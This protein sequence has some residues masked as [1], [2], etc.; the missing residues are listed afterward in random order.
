MSK[1]IWRECDLTQ[2]PGLV[3]ERNALARENQ[4]LRKAAQALHSTVY[5]F[6]Q[7]NGD[8]P[9]ILRAQSRL[10][11]GLMRKPLSP[12]RTLERMDTL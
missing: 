9:A 3:R 7:G 12:S 4:A 2:I 6:L 11:D 5:A 1:M 10:I 8:Q